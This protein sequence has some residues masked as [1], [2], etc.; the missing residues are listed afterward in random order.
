[1][2]ALRWR[3]AM[4]TSGSVLAVALWATGAR[5]H[6]SSAMYDDHQTVTVTGV[7]TRYVWA[8][9][10]V[11]IYVV[12]QVGAQ[13]IEWEIEG[14]PPSILRRVGLSAATL[15]PGDSV[16]VTGKPAKNSARRALLP[17]SIKL[18]EVTV[19]DRKGEVTQLTSYNARAS[20]SERGLE[21]VWVTLLDLKVEEQLD[22]DKLALTPKGRTARKH[23]DERTMHPGTRCVP[24]S[25]PVFMLTPDLKRIRRKDKVLLIDGEF[26]AAQRTIH[27]DAE[28]HDGAP[29]SNQGHSIGRWEGS[30][31]VIDTTQFSPSSIG[32]AYGVPSG[33]GKHLVERLTPAADGKSLTYHF[34]LSDPE[35][36]ATTVKADVRWVFNPT[37]TYAPDKCDPES[38]RHFTQQ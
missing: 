9:P 27:M 1:M 14:G 37:A 12:Q 26:D 2:N 11:Y 22:E 16:T 32:N 20:G 34:E 8:N 10:H 7:V 21:G 6:H 5:A 33:P 35:Y 15:H 28:A 25:A 36:I 13:K 3:L 24:Y 17:T 31:L 38:A 29:V 4:A 30:S 23:F 19:F 18:G